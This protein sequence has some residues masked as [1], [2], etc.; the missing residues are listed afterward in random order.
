MSWYAVYHST[1]GALVSVGSSVADPLPSG[2]ASKTYA[3][4]PDQGQVRWNPTLLDFEPYK[5]APVLSRVQYA[6]RFTAAERKAIRDSTDAT[7]QDLEYQTRLADT[8]DLGSQNV[9]NGV[10]YLESIG[11]IGVGRAA[12]ILAY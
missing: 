7:A 2:L 5:V 10:N 11:L 12:E 6:Q 8:I 3:T 1:D 9:I 4:R